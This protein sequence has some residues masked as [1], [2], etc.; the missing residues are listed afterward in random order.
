MSSSNPKLDFDWISCQYFDK[1]SN[2]CR[3]LKS[4]WFLF[5]IKFNLYLFSNVFI[6]L[7][8]VKSNFP[9]LE[10]NREDNIGCLD[11]AR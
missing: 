11:W 9:S 5:L 1:I 10:K 7:S 3:E 6:G 8:N 4:F 2:L